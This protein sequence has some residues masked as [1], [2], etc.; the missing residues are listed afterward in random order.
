MAINLTEVGAS[1]SVDA[2]G[3]L[4]IKFGLYLPG[5]RPADGFSVAVRV[6]QDAD[7][8]DPAVPPVDVAMS[9]AQGSALDLWTV[10]AALAPD[11]DSH[12]GQ[13]GLYLYRFQLFWT[14]T[15]G[16]RQLITEWFPDPFARETDLG[17]LSAVT[18]T[19]QAPAPFNWTDGAWRTPEIDSLVVYEAQVEQFNDTFAGVV[20]RLVY[21]KSFGVSCIELMPVTSTKLD[22]DWGYGPLNYFAPHAAFGGVAGLKALVNACHAQGVAVILDVVYQHVDVNFAYYQVY[23]D[24]RAN[25]AAPHVPSPMINGVGDFGPEIDF[26]QSFAQDY[27][28]LSNQV[29]LD[30]YHIDGFRYD[31]VTDLYTGPTDTAYAMLSYETYLYSRGIA[32]FGCVPGTYSRLIQCAEALWK[33]PDVLRNTYTNAAWQEG[34]LG[35]AEQVAGGDIGTGTLTN[36]AHALDPFFAGAYPSTKSVVDSAGAAVDMPVAPFQYLNCHDKSHLITFAGTIGSDFL[37]AGNRSFFYRIQ[38]LLVA[39]YTCQGVPMLWEGEEFV[40]D[41]QLPPRGAARINLRRDMH[42]EYFYDDYGSPVIRL[43]RI[44]GALRAANPALRGR[45]SYYYYQQS[46][47][48]TAI[49]AYHRHAPAAG[50]AAEQY[51]MV[52]INFGQAAGQISLPFPAAGVWTEAVDAKSRGDAGQ[53][54]LTVAIVNAGDSESISVPSN[55]GYVFLSG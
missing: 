52:A 33:A 5:I 20:D 12:Y 42:W 48:G 9:W 19:R 54:P 36:L 25:P 45:Q 16:S 49:V 32:R 40:D 27:C 50:A 3:T 23:A 10:T 21:L 14:P 53:P 34:L 46:L 41:Y 24:L 18:C 26:S 44:L 30:D 29:W 22:F 51:A 47:A 39:L 7:R 17:M 43:C 35:V 55:Y 31:E 1:C 28:R 11:P 13:E 6:I 37:A 15:G 8:F 2:G 38:P 4:Q